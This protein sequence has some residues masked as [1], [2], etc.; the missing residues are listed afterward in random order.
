MKVARG[1]GPARL[2]ALRGASGLLLAG[3]AGLRMGA[4]A[5]GAR[6]AGGRGGVESAGMGPADRQ[7]PSRPADAG[8]EPAQE[9]DRRGSGTAG[10]RG[11]LLRR[12]GRARLG[13]GR[14]RPDRARRWP[15]TGCCSARRWPP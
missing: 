15:S 2:G 3:G 8:G 1:V 5:V 14:Y 11:A 6:S 10:E 12:D 7:D 13:G 9:S 4:D